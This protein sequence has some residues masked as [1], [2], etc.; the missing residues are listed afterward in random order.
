MLHSF[1][2]CGLFLEIFIIYEGNR[3]EVLLGHCESYDG[4]SR[5][6]SH[7]QGP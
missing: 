3:S 1:E 5:Q 6:A 7:T 4:G 2:K